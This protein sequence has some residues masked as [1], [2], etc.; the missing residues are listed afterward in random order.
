MKG[1]AVR[2]LAAL[3]LAALALA[4]LAS[5]FLLGMR[6]SPA[7]AQRIFAEGCVAYCA[8][9][10]GRASESGERIELVA[11]RL[12]E[13][14][15]GSLFIQACNFLYPDTV[16]YPYLCWNRNCCRFSVPPP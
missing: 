15:Q 3:M 5:V 12:G 6:L 1:L 2:M 4:V 10:A 13:E 9:I 8:E 11:V 7:E 16:G 14:L